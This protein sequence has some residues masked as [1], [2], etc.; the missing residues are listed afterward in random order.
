ME[1]SVARQ[2]LTMTIMMIGSTR[3]NASTAAAARPEASL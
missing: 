3:N 1:N 2:K